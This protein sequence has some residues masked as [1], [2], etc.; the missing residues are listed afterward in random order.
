MKNFAYIGAT[1]PADA[2]ALLGRSH[3]SKALAG[4][5][6]LIA[7]MRLGILAPDRLV[8]LKTI[9]G[10]KDISF[11]E[12][13]G[14]QLGALATLNDIAENLTVK[15]HYPVLVGAISAAASPQLRNRGTIAGNLCQDSR[16]WYYRGQFRCWLK[17]GD[18]C[19]ASE[20]ENAYHALFGGGP[21]YTVHPS[22]LAP[23]LIALDAAVH[24]V[25]PA[26]ERI[27][28]LE[29]LFQQPRED[30]RRLISLDSDELITAIDVPAPSKE[31]RGKYI[32]AMERGVWSFAL[33]SVAAQV[34]FNND[35]IRDARLVF[36][37]VAAAPWRN[38]QIEE[39]LK[40]TY[41]D[42]ETIDKASSMA[43]ENARPLRHNSY[44]V[45]LIKGILKEALMALRN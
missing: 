7:E 34:I 32:K 31:S 30:A 39:I 4:G 24:I 35:H 21:C 27:L 13:N 45:A 42:D 38:R 6:D 26:G 15:L 23:A 43:G 9:Q 20:G 40:N 37:G 2:V 14:L 11:S 10:L 44:K 41:L 12:I 28:P 22:D 36:G 29:K 25:G 1:S 19:Y 16:C 8:N 3:N 33:A 18:V 17:G 5:M